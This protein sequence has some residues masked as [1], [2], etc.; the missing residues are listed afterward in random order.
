MKLPELSQVEGAALAI[1]L[2]GVA[3]IAYRAIQE[4]KDLAKRA[5]GLP[6]QLEKWAGDKI[7]AGTTYLEKNYND[8]SI[9]AP[10]T[11]HFDPSHWR[12]N[13][14]TGEPELKPEYRVENGGQ[15]Y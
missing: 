5:E 2:A 1:G 6:A 4:V 12:P 7:D 13:F 8:S 11:G 3:Y 15:G 14:W 10:L 9:A